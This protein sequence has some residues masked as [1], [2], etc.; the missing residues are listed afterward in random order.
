MDAKT[1]VELSA[2]CDQG[3]A[4][5]YV[6]NLLFEADMDDHMVNDLTDEEYELKSQAEIA[7]F[8]LA[9]EYRIRKEYLNASDK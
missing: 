4:L 2:T 5:Q 6:L 7:L 3:R 9:N 1:I 8:E